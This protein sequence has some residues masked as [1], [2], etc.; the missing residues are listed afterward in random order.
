MPTFRPPQ[1]TLISGFGAAGSVLAAVVLAFAVTSGIVAY[2]LSSVDPVPRLSGALVLDPLRTAVIAAKPL[3]LRPA[4]PAARRR[5]SAAADAGPAAAVATVRNGLSLHTGD[6][7]VTASDPQ[8]GGIASW[9]PPA[10]RSA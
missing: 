4:R 10:T 6:L 3:V 8:D 7:P 9:S 2:S 1:R 5:A